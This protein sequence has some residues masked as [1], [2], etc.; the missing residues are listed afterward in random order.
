MLNAWKLKLSF[1]TKRSKKEKAKK[2]NDYNNPK[3]YSDR[4]LNYPQCQIGSREVAGVLRKAIREKKARR[5]SSNPLLDC[6]SGDSFE[7]EIAN[8]QI[9]FFID[10]P[11]TYDYIESVSCDGRKSSQFPRS[12]IVDPDL[13]LSDYEKEKL[14]ELLESL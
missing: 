4:D 9:E 1:S 11:G 6:V 10:D 3:I 5:L 2:L 8:Y 14:D 12:W 13:L 7:I